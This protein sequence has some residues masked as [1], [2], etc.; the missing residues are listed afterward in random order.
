M[1]E[2]VE[3]EVGAVNDADRSMAR[4][5][6]ILREHGVE[7]AGYEERECC[8]PPKLHFECIPMTIRELHDLVEAN[9]YQI[10]RFSETFEYKEEKT[11]LP[12]CYDS[13]E[14]VVSEC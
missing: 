7:V 9:G 10:A 12:W 6:E 1:V 14:F 2:R 4:L 13:M 11:G 3:T 8:R 5:A